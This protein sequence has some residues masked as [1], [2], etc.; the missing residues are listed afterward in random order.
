MGEKPDSVRQKVYQA[1]VRGSLDESWSEWFSG[2]TIT[3]EEVGGGVVVTTLIGPVPD[4][5]A[6]LGILTKLGDLNLTLISVSVIEEHT[7]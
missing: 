1:R 3:T 5:P 4:Q 6:L 2:M 7:E